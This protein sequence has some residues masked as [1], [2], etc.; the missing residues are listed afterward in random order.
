MGSVSC[1]LLMSST[2]MLRTK[3][4]WACRFTLS[5]LN[6]WGGPCALVFLNP[7]QKERVKQKLV[8]KTRPTNPLQ[9][10]TFTGKL[11]VTSLR[12]FTSPHHD[13]ILYLRGTDKKAQPW[14]LL[15]LGKLCDNTTPTPG[16]EASALADQRLLLLSDSHPLQ[17]IFCQVWNNVGHPWLLGSDVNRSSDPSEQWGR[18]P[19]H[20]IEILR[21]S[22]SELPVLR[23][24][25]CT[26]MWHETGSGDET[27]DTA[28]CKP[29][30][31]KEPPLIW[32]L[33][34]WNCFCLCSVAPW[35]VSSKRL[36]FC[37][38][39]HSVMTALSQYCSAYACWSHV[40]TEWIWIS[41]LHKKCTSQSLRQTFSPNKWIQESFHISNKITIVTV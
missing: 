16:S 21:Q 27:W 37:S 1:A 22:W 11:K 36:W 34:W 30:G 35:Q 14:K 25:I 26:D 31:P 13:P 38:T 10:F 29:V 2:D 40:D 32:L 19:I 8:E 3:W 7:G 20:I 12:C 18:D 9:S 4:V 23:S 6:F 28:G 41:R 24:D 17:G 39:R 5:Y 15:S 33:I